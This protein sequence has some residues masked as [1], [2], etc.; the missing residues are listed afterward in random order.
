MLYRPFSLERRIYRSEVRLLGG[1]L[2][3]PRRLPRYIDRLQPLHFYDYRHQLIWAAMLS[4]HR[5]GEPV[6]AE[7]VLAELASDSRDDDAGGR[8][9][10]TWLAQFQVE[11]LQA[12]DQ[13][14]RRK[15]S[16]RQIPAHGV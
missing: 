11:P 12:A 16:G 13:P 9:Y 14:A 6:N 3:S 8:P 4:L 5:R 15:A 1:L 2:R 7:T 10:L